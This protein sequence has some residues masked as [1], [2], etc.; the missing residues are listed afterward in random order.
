M[1]IFMELRPWIPFGGGASRAPPPPPTPQL[2]LPRFA[3]FAPL[4]WASLLHSESL[5]RF[6]LISVLMPALGI[7]THP[8]T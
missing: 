1:P 3:P 4:A 5:P 2:L 7:K 8:S 6:L